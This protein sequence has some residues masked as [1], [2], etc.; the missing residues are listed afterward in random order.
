MKPI[1]SL[2]GISLPDIIELPRD[3]IP[4]RY[5]LGSWMFLA[6]AFRPYKGDKNGKLG[7]GY[8]KKVCSIAFLTRSK[9]ILE[10]TIP[11]R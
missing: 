2:L 5:E 7:D 8:M 1:I 11:Y 4:A 6:L 10:A 3:L 9:E